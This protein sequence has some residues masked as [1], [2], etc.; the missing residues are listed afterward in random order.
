[1]ERLLKKIALSVMLCTLVTAESFTVNLSFEQPEDALNTLLSTQVFPNPVG[2]YNGDDYNIYLWYPTVDIESGSVTFTCTIFADLVIG[3]V[4]FQYSYPLS[5]SLTFPSVDVSTSDITALIT[6]I[7]SQIS[8]MDGPQWVKDIIINTYEG[9][10]L[11]AYPDYLL[12]V[13]SD[14]IPDYLDIEITNIGFSYVANTDVLV[15]TLYFTMDS[16]PISIQ[17]YTRT[18]DPRYYYYRYKVYNNSDYPITLHGYYITTTNGTYITYDY[19]V[20]QTIAANDNGEFSIYLGDAGV[21]L[22]YTWKLQ[23]YFGT[24][25]GEW[26][27]SYTTGSTSSY[28]LVSPNIYPSVTN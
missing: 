2:Q 22:R 23:L 19:N 6:G 17:C 12:D 15:F 21:D 3:G 13:S 14:L 4:D 8:S 5:F 10:E 18:G 9:L 11:T 25:N 26:I 24:E 28:T 16:E 7:S 20:Q 1:M 27:Y